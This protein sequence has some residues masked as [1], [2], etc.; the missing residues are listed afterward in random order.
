MLVLDRTRIING[1]L[2]RI[3]CHE[4]L[5][6]EEVNL[7]VAAL[8]RTLDDKV[9][10][11]LCHLKRHDLTAGAEVAGGCEAVLASQ[12]AVMCDVQAQCLDR[13]ADRNVLGHVN[14]IVVR[15]QL[16]VLLEIVQLCVCLAYSRCVVLRQRLHNGVRAGF[17]HL[18][19]DQ[20]GYRVGYVVEQVHGT[21]IDVQ[22][23]IQAFLGKTMDH[24][25]F[26]RIYDGSVL[27]EKGFWE[28]TGHLTQNSEAH[29]PARP[30]ARFLEITCSARTSGLQRCKKSCKRTGKKSG[31]HH[32][33]R[34][35][36]SASGLRKSGS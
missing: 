18:L 16:A 26:L 35:L 6:A 33:R 23:E 24:R 27:S 29:H 22:Q 2:D 28:C 9:D 8:A 19:I 4:R 11:L 36:Q 21:A 7:D 14:V 34:V 17:G 5:A 25:L 13:C 12:V 30:A 20:A 3:P 31:T 10:R 1:L 32:S 15:E